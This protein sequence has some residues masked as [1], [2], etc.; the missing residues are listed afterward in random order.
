MRGAEAYKGAVPIPPEHNATLPF[1]RNAIGSMDYT[2]VTFSA[3]GRRT[4]AGHELALSVVFESGLQHFADR[5]DVYLATRA[6]RR[7][8]RGIP[9]AWDDT[10]LVDGYPGASAT[11]AR[12]SGRSWYVGAISAGPAADRAAAAPVPVPRAP[13]P[14]VDR[15]GRPGRHAR[16]AAPARDAGGACCGSR[17]APPAATRSAS[18]PCG[19]GH[20]GRRSGRPEPGRCQCATS[21]S[22]ASQHR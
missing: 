21:G 6:V 17:W 4:S 3:P 2:P 22:P 18:A 13:L 1:T 19:A 5:P 10:R 14:G 7:W 9:A 11:I 12:R 16:L 20:S 8:L 15:G